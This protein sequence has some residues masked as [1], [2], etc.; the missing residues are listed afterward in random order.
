MDKIKHFLRKWPRGYYIIQR[1]WHSFRR[2]LET[3]IL[4]TKLQELIWKT[5]H[6]YKGRRWAEEY[7]QSTGHPHRKQIVEA[8]SSFY[9]F[10]SVLEIGCNSGPNLILLSNKFPK[11]KFIGI[12]INKVAIATGKQ[13]LNDMEINNIQLFEG[14]ADKL[15][16]LQDKSID[17]VFTDAVLMFIGKDK[18]IN[19]L[20]EMGRITRKGFILNEYH[21]T[22]PPAGNYEDGRWIYNHIEL[23]SQLYPSSQIKIQKS[24]FTGG[25]WDEYGTLI[26]VW[27]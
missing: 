14:K 26:E 10:E 11:V 1:I 5:R 7:L 23:I 15:N 6:I 27:L 12:D 21:S 13:Y 24:A 8:I 17:V 3:Y 16:L 9:P 20:K 25:G 22:N 2:I 19:V 4:G 18:I